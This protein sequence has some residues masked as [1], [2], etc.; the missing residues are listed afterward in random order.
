MAIE[1]IVHAE[2]EHHLLHHLLHRQGIA[3]VEVALREA[4]K[5]ALLVLTVVKIL[6]AYEI[7]VP[8]SLE[9]TIVEVGETIE[10]HRR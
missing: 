8:N 3:Q 5:R 6:A 4:G 2:A 7:G 10:D 9:P 1:E